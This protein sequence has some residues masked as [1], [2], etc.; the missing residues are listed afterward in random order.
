MDGI[1][2]D[3]IYKTIIIKKTAK[4]IIKYKKFLFFKDSKPLLPIE[5]DPHLLHTIL[6][7][8]DLSEIKLL[9]PH[10]KHIFFMI[11]IT[12]LLSNFYYDNNILNIM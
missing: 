11:F 4:I 3:E 5:E 7:P 10:L 12:N 2:W 8:R 6:P 1:F 9:Q